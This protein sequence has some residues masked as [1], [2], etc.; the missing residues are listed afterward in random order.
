[1]A[2]TFSLHQV[3]EPGFFSTNLWTGKAGYP[4]ST[5]IPDVPPTN[6]LDL[7]RVRKSRADDED[8]RHI[9]R[10][11]V[12]IG[13]FEI[14]KTD[15][16]YVEISVASPSRVW[17]NMHPEERRVLLSLKVF[18]P[19][20]RGLFGGEYDPDDPKRFKLTGFSSQWEDQ[21]LPAQ[22]VVSVSSHGAALLNTEDF[23][24]SRTP[25]A[26]SFFGSTEYIV[27][28]HGEGNHLLFSR[29][30][31][32]E[33]LTLLGPT[34]VPFSGVRVHN[35]K[36]PF[37]VFKRTADDPEQVYAWAWFGGSPS[38]LTPLQFVQEVSTGRDP[39]ATALYVDSYNNAFWNGDTDELMVGPFTYRRNDREF[40][41]TARGLVGPGFSMFG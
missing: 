27:W 26:S 16:E 18:R 32:S 33:A 39:A 17:P 5:W 12:A 29:T 7:D 21:T 11:A 14:P 34:R 9:I 28:K 37:H 30:V 10:E 1:M 36:S 23:T 31:G 3:I 8:V 38:E 19:A 40:D 25:V 20:V 2:S 41:L 22:Y 15:S 35:P 24:W 4:Q 6:I 13:G